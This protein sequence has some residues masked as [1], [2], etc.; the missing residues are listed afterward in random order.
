MYDAS[1]VTRGRPI[2]RLS[3]RLVDGAAPRTNVHVVRQPKMRV[4]SEVMYRET[5]GAAEVVSRGSTRRKDPTFWAAL[6]ERIVP[7]PRQGLRTRC[8]A[9]HLRRS[10]CNRPIKRG[11]ARAPEPRTKAKAATG[12]EEGYKIAPGSILC[13]N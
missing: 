11:G 6:P 8:R 1:R 7:F 5:R 4:P 10:R 2:R 13:W 12:F 3:S 9:R